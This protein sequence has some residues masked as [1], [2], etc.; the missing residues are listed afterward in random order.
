M[1]QWKYHAGEQSYYREIHVLGAFSKQ[2]EHIICFIL[3]KLYK[4]YSTQY[5][6]LSLMLVLTY[7]VYIALS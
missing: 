7:I 6:Y 3:N 1:L 4:Q 5:C 2:L